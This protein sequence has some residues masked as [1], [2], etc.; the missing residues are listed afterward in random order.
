MNSLR[1]EAAALEEERLRELASR[2]NTTVYRAQHDDVDEAWK[3]ATLRPVIERLTARVK[4]FGDD[5]SDFTVR[6]ECLDDEEIL[7]FQR[8][9]PNMYW[10]LTDRKM[11]ADANFVKIMHDFVRVRQRVERGDIGSQ[12]A[13][14]LATEAVLSVTRGA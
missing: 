6:K 13:D 2:P 7:A 8:R 1:A 10:M 9:H 5:V 4:A 12:E 3:V 11:V 14:A